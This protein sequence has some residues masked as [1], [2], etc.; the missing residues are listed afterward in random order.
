M[1]TQAA[2]DKNTEKANALLRQG[3]VAYSNWENDKARLLWRKA[4]VS[5]P[6]NEDI[7]L[8]L[9]QVLQTDEDRK[10]C[11]QNILILNPENTEIEQRLRMLESETQP[12]VVQAIESEVE[13]LRPELGTHVI[14]L[15]RWLL[16]TV[17]LGMLAVIL[18]AI[19]VQIFV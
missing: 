1:Q 3:Y 10:V 15:M 9:L 12:A 14:T 7:W 18:A 16:T 5:D 6:A 4:A 19:L 11:M 2:I 13:P 17:I 8:A